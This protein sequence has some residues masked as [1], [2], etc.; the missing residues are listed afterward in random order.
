MMRKAAATAL[1]V[2]SIAL[3]ALPAWAEIE[4]FDAAALLP[5]FDRLRQIDFEDLQ[6]GGSPPRPGERA[7]DVMALQMLGVTFTDPF[8]L[9]TGQCASP[10][11]YPDPRNATGGN[12]E[13]YLNPGGEIAFATSPGLVVLDIEGMG[14]NP[15][16][17]VVTD[18]VGDTLAVNERGA[19]FDRTLLG[20][21]ASNGVQRITV[22]QVGGTQGPLALARV[23][24]SPTP[25]AQH[26]G[27]SRLVQAGPTPGHGPVSI[28]FALDH[29]APIA[30]D[31]FDVQ[32]RSIASPA[33]G[34]WPPGTHVVEWNGL[35]RNGDPAPWGIYLVR[36]AY[37]GGQDQ[38]RVVRLP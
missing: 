36:Y 22:I 21:H 28:T 37:P 8:A 20:L 2:A 9:R 14:Y 27:A 17:L 13:L 33:R 1:A 35:T 16:E 4:V 25:T 32:G 30:I 19:A 6:L 10:T 7:V 23:L 24:F 31:V 11:C 18:G 12:N 34:V 38:R 29:A 26:P 3:L 5:R 15:F